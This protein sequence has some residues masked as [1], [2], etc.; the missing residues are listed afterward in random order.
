MMERDLTKNNHDQLRSFL[1]RFG[2]ILVALVV[3]LVFAAINSKFVTL[4]NLFNITK[5]ISITAVTSIGMTAVFLIGGMD[6]SAGSNILLSAVITGAFITDASL[7]T[8]LAMAIA[9]AACTVMGLLNGVLIEKFKINSVI[10][11]LGSQLLIRGLGLVLLEK[12]NS[13]MWT[14]KDSVLS[15]INKG[16]IVGIPVLFF[17]MA[18]LYA[19]AYLVFTRTSFGRQIYA[20]GGNEKAAKLC[21]LNTSWIKIGCFVMSGVTAGIAG[22]IAA[23]RLGVVNPSVGTGMEFNAVTAVVLG[24]VSLKGGEGNVLKTFVGALIVGF[25]VNFMTLYG[26]DA[27]Y[28]S[29]VTGV[30]IL[31]AAIFNWSTAARKA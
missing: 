13:W 10:L 24:G 27:N 11:T 9:I 5:Q 12:Y 28:Q 16:T 20:A 8:G 18:L 6:L 1:E 22:I 29:V 15:Y 31:L 14:N 26:V 30:F 7:P 25:I 19:I 21:G 3:M 2:I 4:D 17:I 23:S